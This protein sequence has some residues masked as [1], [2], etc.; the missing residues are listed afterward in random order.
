MRERVTVVEGG[1]TQIM[2]TLRRMETLMTARAA[3]AAPAQD[4]LTL[5]LHNL[6]DGLRAQT[7]QKSAGGGNMILVALALVGMGA[8]GFVLAGI[9]T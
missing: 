8:I 1:Q 5:A 7:T 6:A 4:T 3:P 9:L 2:D